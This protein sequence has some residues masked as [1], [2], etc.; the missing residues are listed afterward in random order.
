MG[1]KWRQHTRCGFCQVPIELDIVAGAATRVS[2]IRGWLPHV[3]NCRNVKAEFCPDA[4]LFCNEEHLGA[5]RAAAG[6]P[7][8][9]VMDLQALSNLG[10]RSG[11]SVNAGYYLVQ[12]QIPQSVPLARLLD[13][14][15]GLPALTVRIWK[16]VAL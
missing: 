9:L 14:A 3:E 1:L 15:L 11:G 12:N 7:E 16:T 5:W 6:M 10:R 13:E 4:N 8:E 2:P